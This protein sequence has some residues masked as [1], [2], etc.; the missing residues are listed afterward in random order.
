[1]R[2]AVVS[3]VVDRQHGTERA[4][5]ELID[6]LAITYG[7]DV[8]LYAQHVRDIRVQPSNRDDRRTGA[9]IH[10][11]RIGKFPGPHVVQFLG[12]LILNRWS[13]MNR[14]NAL[15]PNVTFSPGINSLDSDVVLVHAVFHRLAELQTARDRRGLRGLHRKLYYS[16]LQMLERRIY[17]D[18]RVMLAAVSKHTALQLEHYFGRRDVTVIPNAVDVNHFSIAAI[19]PLRHVVR[20]QQNCSAGQTVLLLIGNDWRNKGLHAL[21]A[22]MAQYKEL[23]LRLLVVGRDEQAPFRAQAATAGLLDR[24]KFCP[25]VPDVR[26]FYAAADILVAPS[27]EDSFNLPA[28]EAM[29]CGVPVIVSRYAGVSEWLT[30]GFD[31]LVLN[32]AENAAELAEAIRAIA[33]G[34]QLRATLAANAV[35]TAGKF[36]WDEHAAQLRSLLLAAAAK[37]LRA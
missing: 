18:S 36:S 28:L 21:L 9:A 11:H 27:L 14:A 32:N 19:A 1:V 31:A 6:R 35:V 13:R 20:A 29:A 3:P 26:S 30:H 4:V 12:W 22:A 24:V 25:P 5:A 8:E 34:A 23:P 33:T 17:R 2:V 37:K 15:A 7:D 10:W 16:L